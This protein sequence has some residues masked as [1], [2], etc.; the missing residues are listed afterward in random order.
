MTNPNGMRIKSF[1]ARSVDDAIQQARVELGDD[2]MMLNTRKFAACGDQPGGYEVVFGV[3][4]DA[5][6]APVTGPDVRKLIL[7]AAEKPAPVTIAPAPKTAAPAPQRPQRPER[8]VATAPVV[9]KY[10]ELAGELEKLY[11][12][13]NEI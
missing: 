10:D 13:M 5:A 12:Q 1:F 3:A 4:G 2:A 7:P 11:A 9:E 6:P 8:V